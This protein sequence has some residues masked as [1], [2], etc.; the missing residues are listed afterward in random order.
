MLG[1]QL[2]NIKVYSALILLVFLGVD[3]IFRISVVSKK[4]RLLALE[5]LRFKVHWRFRNLEGKLKN[6]FVFYRVL[7]N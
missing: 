4:M 5:A 2:C 3:D 7:L 6:K 1:K